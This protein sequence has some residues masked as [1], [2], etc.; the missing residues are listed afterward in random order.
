MYG[1]QAKNVKEETNEQTNRKN[2][3]AYYGIGIVTGHDHAE[4]DSVCW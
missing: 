2:K 1:N 3:Q 4:Y